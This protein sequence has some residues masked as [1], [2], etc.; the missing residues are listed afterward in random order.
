M[1]F[2]PHLGTRLSAT[3]NMAGLTMLFRFHYMGFLRD[4]KGRLTAE[5]CQT[6]NKVGRWAKRVL[7]RE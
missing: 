4:R 3:L 6:A 1:D 5:L 7:D 2:L